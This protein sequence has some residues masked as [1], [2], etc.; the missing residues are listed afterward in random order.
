MEN[1]RP[2]V[3]FDI[4]IGGEPAG[5]IILELYSDSVPKTAENFRALCTGEKGLN[6]NGIPLHFKGC[7]FHRVI[8]GFMIQGGDFTAGNGTGGESIYGAK[9]DDENFEQKHTR[10]MLLS[11]A[12]AGPN[13]NGSQ[14]F[15]TSKPTPHLDGRHVVFGEVLKG[16]NV[17]RKIENSPTGEQD[18]PI[19]DVVIVNC[20]ELTKSDFEAVMKPS[21]DGDEFADYP[22]DWRGEDQVANL[23]ETL[24]IAEKIRKVGND[25][26]KKSDFS[27]ALEKYKKAVRYI[28]YA[29][30][31]DNDK[32]RVDAALIPCYSNIAICEFKLNRWSEAILYSTKTLQLDPNNTKALLRRSQSYVKSKD[33]TNA[34][35]DITAALKL[36]PSNKELLNH[37]ALV[38]KT[39]KQ[40]KEKQANVYKNMFGS[41]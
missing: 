4:T 8:K 16:Q 23:N 32:K 15:I 35:D 20:G 1:T 24:D 36:D 6:S 39:W 29:D 28:Q 26:F 17:V 37:Q 19:K 13:T 9:F 40:W 41:E 38:N 25:Y 33:F 11:M 10:G 34:R 30:A 27:T 3:Y 14:F 21:A 22:E 18:K 31:E 5:K 7:T 12:N 2:K